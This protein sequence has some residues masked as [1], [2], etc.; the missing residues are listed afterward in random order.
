MVECA[1]E[2]EEEGEEGEGEEV[3][4]VFVVVVVSAFLLGSTTEMTFLSHPHVN[5]PYKLTA[6]GIISYMA[7]SSKCPPLVATNILSMADVVFSFA[8][9]SLLSSVR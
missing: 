6:I 4:V 2:D 7:I 8:P 1:K 9:L 5:P 3:I